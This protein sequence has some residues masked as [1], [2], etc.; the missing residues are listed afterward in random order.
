MLHQ[1]QRVE[2]ADQLLQEFIAAIALMLWAS[3]VRQGLN[4]FSQVPGAKSQ[5]IGIENS[6]DAVG[7]TTSTVSLCL[8]SLTRQADTVE[9]VAPAASCLF[10]TLISWP[11]APGTWLK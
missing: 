6:H 9:V 2:R 8:A 4:H 7:A 1:G 11:F 5:E 3:R 10:S